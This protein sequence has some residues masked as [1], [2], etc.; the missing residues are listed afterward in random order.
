MLSFYL[1]W[2]LIY[3]LLLSELARFWPEKVSET[4]PVQTV[5][6]VT[7]LI[8]CRN[9]AENIDCLAGQL[10][11][12]QFPNLELILVDDNS[13]DDTFESITAA[14]LRDQRIVPLRS[15]GE[16]KKAALEF[17]VTQAKGEIIL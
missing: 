7:I 8:P 16:G 5:P 6:I 15:P 4:K 1:I 10:K 13:E 11:N 17:G 3:F 14:G 12:L 9:E 2:T